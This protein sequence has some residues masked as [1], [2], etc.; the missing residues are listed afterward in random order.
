LSRGLQRGFAVAALVLLVGLA[1]AAKILQPG[2]KAPDGSVDSAEPDGRKALLLLLREIGFDAE[3]WREAPERLASERGILWLPC[4]P[5]RSGPVSARESGPT[6]NDRAKETKGPSGEKESKDSPGEEGTEGDR[7]DE[8]PSPARAGAFGLAHYAEFVRSGGVLVIAA[9]KETRTFLA[10]DL[11]VPASEI[12]PVAESADAGVRTFTD[13]SGETFSIDVGKAGVFVP[14]LPGFPA[15]PI[16]WARG[17]DGRGEEVLAAGIP[18]GAGQVVLLGDDAF[19]A[20]LKLGAHDHAYLAAHLADALSSVA[21]SAPSSPA[22]SSPASD[23]RVLFDEY[24]LGTWQPETPVAILASPRFFLAS[25][26][27]LLLLGLVVLRAAWS[28]EF[29]RDPLTQRTTSPLLRARALGGLLVRAGR[30]DVLSR[31]LLEG[32]ARG[33]ERRDPA[34]A[35]ALRERA[36][37]PAGS[38]RELEGLASEVRAIERAAG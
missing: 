31:F 19:L 14:E 6:K 21:S 15:R 25:L 28:R 18:L 37:R 2:S 38:A 11:G 30:F 17:D 26:H 12:P 3:A 24:A 32:A 27:A 23:R 34:G 29:P 22:S 5:P 35:R 1:I 8:L 4:V 16:V 13:E 20:N 10:E 7:A 36:A 9:G 33:L